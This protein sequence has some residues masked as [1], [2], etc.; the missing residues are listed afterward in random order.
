MDN[1][2]RIKSPGNGDA[3]RAF[4]TIYTGVQR[5]D[6]TGG[7]GSGEITVAVVR[8]DSERLVFTS[9]PHTLSFGTDPLAVRGLVFRLQNGVFPDAG[10]YWV[11]F[12]YNG[13]AI[14]R[15]PLLVR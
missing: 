11:E 13:K 14:A 15:Q 5:T 2:D 4:L 6:R 1:S 8:A 3:S 12:R 7:R 10:L 9:L